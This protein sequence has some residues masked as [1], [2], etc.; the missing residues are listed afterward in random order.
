[1]RAEKNEALMKTRLI[2]KQGQ[3]G[4]KY[5]SEKY[6]DDLLYVRFRYDAESR[7]RLKTVEL[8][9]EKTPWTPPRPRYAA[10]TLVPLRIEAADM[11][12]RLQ[13][14]AAGGRWDPEKKLWYIKHGKIAGTPLEKHIQVDTF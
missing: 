10:D 14:K 8:I 9:V 5:L 3:R 2:L 4:T 7:Q 12:A 11:P 13:V 6:G 1:M